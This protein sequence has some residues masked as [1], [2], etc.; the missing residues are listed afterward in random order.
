MKLQGSEFVEMKGVNPIP[1]LTAYTCSFA[2][3][4]EQAGILQ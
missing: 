2:R 3:G 4:L 1:M